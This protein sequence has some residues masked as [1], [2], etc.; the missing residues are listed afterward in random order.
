MTLLSLTCRGISLS[1][2]GRNPIEQ[3]A[4]LV[5]VVYARDITVTIDET[6]GNDG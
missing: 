1:V 6:D 3:M 4:D 5:Q 2:A